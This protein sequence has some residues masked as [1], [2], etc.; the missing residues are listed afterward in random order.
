METIFKTVYQ[1]NKVP[2][3]AADMERL[4]EIAR[5]C[6]EVRNYVYGRYGGI[7]SLPKIYPGYTVQNEMT[8]SG[9]RE[10][11]GLPS[12]YFYLAI[13]DALGDIKSQWARTKSLVEKNIRD[14][15][16]MTP[17]EK[18]YLRFV[19]KQGQCFEA[20]LA[21]EKPVLPENWKERYTAVCEKVDTHR[22]NQYLR[23]QVRRHLRVPHTDVADGFTVSPKGYRYADHGIYISMKESRK[24]LF[25][26]LT[27]N[28][29]YTRQVYV[30]LHPEKGKVTIH[31]PVEV[32]QK[33]P[34]GYGGEVGLAL[35]L[36]CMFVT[37]HGNAYGENYIEYQSALT[38]Y[39]RK[40][41]PRHRKN[42]KNNPG[43][44]KYS[45]QKSRLEK[46]MHTYVN[47][48]INRMLETEKPG[49]LYIPKLPATPKAGVN[50]RMNATVS[51]WQRGF[52]R[53]RLTQ[54]CRE[55]SVEVVEVFGK[56]ISAECSCCGA[57]GR[58]DGGIFSCETCGLRMP[59]RQNAA[60]NAL[61][62]G[63]ALRE[64]KREPFNKEKSSL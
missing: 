3:P 27:D 11:L 18:H 9:L 42:R 35:G 24:R 5:D 15:P 2:I 61:K 20:V 14:H 33:H 37:D 28:N 45:A 25:I 31:I 44:K 12:V 47:A 6:R 4:Q 38:D 36:R 19:M 41:L 22:L 23:R 50:K 54:K 16:N 29:R 49:V 26:L 34:A 1:Y 13:F 8:K 63:Q 52:V 59:E 40:R 46:A 30:S 58:K 51:M 21:G 7:R 10:R 17:E 64:E 32:K 43:T 53:S 55:R 48:E 56:G 39:V 62:R 60:V 57:G